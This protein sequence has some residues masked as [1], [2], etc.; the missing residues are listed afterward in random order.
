MFGCARGT[1]EARLRET[2]GAMQQ[3]VEA[4]SSASLVDHVAEDY[5]GPDGSDQAALRRTAQ[6]AFL[7]HRQVGVTLGPVDV[8][9]SA[10][11]RHAQASFTAA[12]SGGNGAPLPGSVNVYRVKSGWRLAGGEWQLTS[13]DWTGLD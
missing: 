8:E 5:V 13:L 2:L 6:A 11:G 10:D 12:V 9:M 1:P 3:A 4:R 7:R